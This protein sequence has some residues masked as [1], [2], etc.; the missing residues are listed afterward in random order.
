MQISM[1]ESE[2]ADLTAQLE[3]AGGSDPDI[4][5]AIAE[6]TEILE[7]QQADLMAQSDELD[8]TLAYEDAVSAVR[9]L[10]R[11]QPGRV[12]TSSSSPSSSSWTP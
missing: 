9:K 1:T 3:A 8:A 11:L 6:K 7:G 12:E 4:E 5:D 10:L 2:I